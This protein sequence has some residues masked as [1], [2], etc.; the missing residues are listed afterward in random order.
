MNFEQ[1]L[2]I[3]ITGFSCLER[4][5]R[6]FAL[7]LEG[8]HHEKELLAGTVYK[9]TKVRGTDIQNVTDVLGSVLVGFLQN[10]G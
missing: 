10:Q 7:L 4:F 6:T 9:D 5:G 2:I 1:S 3:P 8:I